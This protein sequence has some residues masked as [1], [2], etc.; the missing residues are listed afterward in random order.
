MTTIA[1]VSE[2]LGTENVL[3]RAVTGRMH[4]QGKTVGEA[5]D[6]LNA[7]LLPEE[8]G[9]LVIVQNLLP[10]QFFSASQQYRLTELMA[11]WRVARDNSTPFSSELQTELNALVEA[12]LQATTHRA[13][14]IRQDLGR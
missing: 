9:L 7:Q 13:S 11:Q 6:A 8:S 5:I 1:I 12:E 14:H 4:S 2:N 3:Y 10:D